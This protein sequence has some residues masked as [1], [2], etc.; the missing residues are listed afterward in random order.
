VIGITNLKGQSRI[1]LDGI[2]KGIRQDEKID[3]AGN[4]ESATREL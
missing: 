4:I 1:K 2:L 3:I